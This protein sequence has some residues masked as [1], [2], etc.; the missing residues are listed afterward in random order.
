LTKKKPPEELQKRGVK[1]WYGEKTVT[2]SIKVPASKKDEL[3]EK[4]AR[5]LKRWQVK[6][7]TQ[8]KKK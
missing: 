3:K 4:V 5:I 7:L 2:L 6:A 1:P 8:K